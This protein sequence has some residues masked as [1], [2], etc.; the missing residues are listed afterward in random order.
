M[1]D[2]IGRVVVLGA[3]GF[4]GRALHAHLS[5]AGVDVVGYSSA[6]L[7][8]TRPDAADVLAAGHV[9]PTTLVFASALTPDRG[10]DL[11]AFTA[12]MTMV[13]SVARYVEAHALRQCVYVSSDG[14]YGFDV[15]PV[16]ETTPVAPPGYYGLVKYA[17]EKVMEY[18]CRV[19]G[20]PLLTLRFAGVF[21]PGDTHSAYGPNAFARSLAKAR[22]V[23]VFGNGEEERDHIYIDDVVRLTAALIRSGATGILNVATGENRP[24]SDVVKVIRGLVPYDVAVENVP[25]KEPVTHRSYDIAR[26]HRLVPGYEFAPFTDAVRATL[27]SFGAL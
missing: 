16:T 4:I 18:A 21:G 3:S 20:V 14:V 11:K 27:A 1:S 24:F 25:R 10:Q 5:A 6:T 8:L 2:P 15:N 13:A 12:N 22:T 26:L 9:E 7:D 23:R 19:K 17:G